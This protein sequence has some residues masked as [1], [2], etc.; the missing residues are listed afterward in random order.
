MKIRAVAITSIMIFSLVMTLFASDTV[1]VTVQ[2][3]PTSPDAFIELREQIAKTPEGGATMAILAMMTF[4]ENETL[5]KQF[6]TI[7][8]DRSQIES[9][10]VYKGYA[11]QRSFNYHLSRMKDPGRKHLYRSYI[12]GTSPESNYQASL[13][14][15]FSFTRNRY[16][17]IKRDDEGNPV[18]VK[19]FAACSGASSPRPLA[20]KKNASGIW[21]A[22]EMSSLFLDVQAPASAAP[23]D[24]L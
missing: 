3:M 16:S 7:A 9:G 18:Q 1:T 22:Y 12:V 13:P 21:K 19:V 17:V 2:T 4:V 6:L 5:G 23:V 11:P 10:N 20:M 14:Y 15:R 8:L 24:E